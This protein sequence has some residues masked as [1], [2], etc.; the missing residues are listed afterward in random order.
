MVHPLKYVKTVEPGSPPLSM[1]K[2]PK[3]SCTLTQPNRGMF[4][5]S[6]NIASLAHCDC[7]A[8]DSVWN[9]RRCS[10]HLHPLEQHTAPLIGL[11]SA[12]GVRHQ[13][14]GFAIATGYQFVD[15]AQSASWG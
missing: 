15:T 2:L 4:D 10:T 9:R 7:F 5:R 12:S 8:A 14:V 11:G 6:R 13:H 3:I 1:Q